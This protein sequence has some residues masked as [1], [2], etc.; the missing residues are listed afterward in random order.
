MTPYTSFLVLESDEDRQRYGVTRR[1][2]MRDGEQFF[3]DARDKAKTEVLRQQIRLARTWRL[4]LR[5]Q[6]L[7]EIARLGKDLQSQAVAYGQEV[8]SSQ[9]RSRRLGKKLKAGEF[10]PHEAP[11]LRDVMS[12]EDVE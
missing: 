4:N 11:K 10:H 6:M 5:T 9:R 12:G 1:V 3:A 7:R 8:L 2:K